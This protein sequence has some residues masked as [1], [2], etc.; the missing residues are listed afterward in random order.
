M[1][2]PTR[3]L[4]E[5]LQSDAAGPLQQCQDFGCFATF[6]RAGGLGTFRALLALGAPVGRAG[7]LSR[8][9]FRGRN[10]GLRGAT[11]ARLAAFG[12]CAGV[13]GWVL[14]CSSA[15]DVIVISW[16]GKMPDQDIHPS[17]VAARQAAPFDKTLRIS[18]ISFGSFPNITCD[19]LKAIGY[20]RVST[21]RQAE[22]GVS[23]EAQEA[24]IRAMATVQGADLLEV[25]IDGGE[26]A[27][28][29]NR[30]G[31]KRLIA[32]VE[33][34]KVEAVIIAKLDRLTRSVKDLCSLLELFE[35]R[36]VALIS[37]AES[38]DTASA[39]GRL[40]ITI[41]AAVSQW[42]R[43]AIGERTRDALRHKRSSGERVGNIRFGFRLSPDGKHVEPDPGEQGVLTEIGHLRQRGHTL[44]G[45]AAALDRQS[46]R[47]RRGSAWRLEHVARIIKQ[48]ASR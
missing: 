13:T 20:V 28:N 24:K 41:I 43:E 31:L 32:R 25:I 16:C 8:L 39:A 1:R 47:T 22:Q 18:L 36:G 3:S 37:V 38:L 26:S 23:L 17:D 14:A 10:T 29:L 15:F 33:S 2:L 12:G 6:P 27:K 7:L 11:S 48:A 44:R 30:P 34:G 19:P 5:F 46:L 4:P 40:V 9:G 21:D 42:E 45:I 35:K